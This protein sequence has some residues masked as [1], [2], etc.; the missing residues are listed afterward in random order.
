MREVVLTEVALGVGILW[1]LRQRVLQG[2]PGSGQVP[3]GVPGT[4]QQLARPAVHWIEVQGTPAHHRQYDARCMMEP[5]RSMRAMCTVS[6]TRH[7][8]SAM[9][10]PEQA[11]RQR[12]LTE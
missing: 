1:A 12:K 7:L 9:C 2:V 3:E 5:R 4:A 11:S 6:I 10:D 8:I